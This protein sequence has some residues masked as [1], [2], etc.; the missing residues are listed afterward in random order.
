MPVLELEKVDEDVAVREEESDAIRQEATI[1]APADQSATSVLQRE[2]RRSSVT[3]PPKKGRGKNKQKQKNKQRADEQLLD[4][5]TQAEPTAAPPLSRP[6]PMT[7]LARPLPLLICSVGNPGSQYANTLHSAGHTVLNKLAAHLGGYTQFSKDKSMG[8]GLVSRGSGD[9]T[10]WQSTAY[11]NESGKGVRAAWMNWSKTA[12]EGR[13]VIVHDELEKPL[14]AVSLRT[15]QGLSAKG[16]NGIKSILAHLGNTPFARIGIGIGRPTSRQSDDVARYVLRKMDANEK[17]AVEGCV[18]E[19]VK[20][21]KLL[22]M[23]KG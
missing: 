14:G 5:A 17:T 6:P 18:E 2:R 13:L 8:N 7:A 12:E 10:L 1:P 19:V 11:M 9:W 16:H 22:E 21:L 20:K 15:A 23:G 4:L 3:K